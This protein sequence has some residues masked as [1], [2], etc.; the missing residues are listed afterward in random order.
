MAD[1]NTNPEE[2]NND[3][4]QEF[5][6][7]DENF[8][9]PDLDYQPVDELEE[10]DSTDAQ[11]VQDEETVSNESEES[12]Y[13]S[14]EQDAEEDS[15]TYEVSVEEELPETSAMQADEEASTDDADYVPGT[16]AQK[17]QE[18]SSGGSKIVGIIV[19]IVVVVGM[20]FGAFYMFYLLPKKKEEEKAKQEL[21]A[22]QQEEERKKQDFEKLVAQGDAQF[23]AEEWNEAESSYSQASALYPN[24]QYPK[25]QLAII[26]TKLDELAAAT[27]KREGVVET[28]SSPMQRF[29]IVVSSSVDGDLAMDYATK[30]SKE[31]HDVGVIQ[32]YGDKKYYRVI[33][34]SYD[35][36]QD[37]EAAVSSFSG[38]YGNGTWIL[39]Y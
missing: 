28:I 15:N 17:M 16:Y 31:G 9:L 24:E 35:T 26:R 27:E 12:S 20:G 13:S 36:W 23:A 33:L 30:I 37:A 10:E 11:E 8:G 7:I 21:I 34:G 32:P 18:E 38:T 4:N 29:H 14:E 25:D 5:N 39:K 19:A 3:Q 2:E 1:K 6:D 22:K